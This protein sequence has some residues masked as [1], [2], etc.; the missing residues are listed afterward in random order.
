[1][2]NIYINT[3]NKEISIRDN[4]HKLIKKYSNLSTN[5]ANELLSSIKLF[6]ISLSKVCN[7]NNHNHDESCMFFITDSTLLR[8][9]KIDEF[10]IRTHIKKE[11][12]SEL[13]NKTLSS[14]GNLLSL[15]SKFKNKD[16]VY[17][18]VENDEKYELREKREKFNQLQSEIDIEIQDI[19]H[20]I[21]LLEDEE[22][23][24]PK[25]LSCIMKIRHLRRKRNKIKTD[26]KK[27]EQKERSLA[28]EKIKE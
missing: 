28:H 21:Q 14:L 4:K 11:W 24:E 26:I 6:M 27:I 7:I 8:Y 5:N 25:S 13:D 12:K 20:E 18:D 23:T 2:L 22:I 15:F 17:W 19:L 16:I 9:I 10:N 3:L 1:M